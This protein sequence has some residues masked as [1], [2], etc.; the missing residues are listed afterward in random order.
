MPKTKSTKLIDEQT[1]G[2]KAYA[3]YMAGRLAGSVTADSPAR[4]ALVARYSAPSRQPSEVYTFLLG[5]REASCP[6]MDPETLLTAV[7]ASLG[8]AAEVAS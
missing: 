1:L 7:W 2:D 8:M 5:L 3:A 4:W 6:L